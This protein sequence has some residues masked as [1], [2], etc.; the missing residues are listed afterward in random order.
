MALVR[1]GDGW[2][3]EGDPDDSDGSGIDIDFWNVH[4]GNHRPNDDDGHRA[5]DDNESQDSFNP[6]STMETGMDPMNGIETQVGE[7]ELKEEEIE[8]DMI[9]G[10]SLRI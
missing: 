3:P 7:E 2:D 6:N 5:D 10:K 4:G 1:F 8:T 9:N